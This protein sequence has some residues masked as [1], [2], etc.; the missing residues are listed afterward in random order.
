MDRRARAAGRGAACHAAVVFAA[1]TPVWNFGLE[2]KVDLALLMHGA[3]AML[4]FDRWRAGQERSALVLAGAFAGF[5]ASTKLFGLLTLA[6]LVAV[7]LVVIVADRR[8]PAVLVAAIV[9]TLLAGAPWYVRTWAVAGHPFWP[10]VVVEGAPSAGR[11]VE[12]LARRVDGHRA[13]AG[14][15]IVRLPAAI[16]GHPDVHGRAPIGP[17]EIGRAHV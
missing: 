10:F 16:A 7:V 5:A 3:L 1:I 17:L 12:D 2:G 15:V 4:A 13:A 8:R 11:I 14:N 6:A 9:V